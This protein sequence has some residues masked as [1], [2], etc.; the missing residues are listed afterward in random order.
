MTKSLNLIVITD[1]V[2]TSQIDLSV[3]CPHL[4]LELNPGITVSNTIAGA[5]NW[6]VGDN[7]L[8]E[9]EGAGATIDFISGPT[10]SQI[11]LQNNQS[12]RRGANAEANQI[13]FTGSGENQMVDGASTFQDCCFDSA[14][15]FNFE[16]YVNLLTITGCL[17]TAPSKLDSNIGLLKSAIIIGNLFEN[18][19]DVVVEGTSEFVFTNNILGKVLATNLL[20]SGATCSNMEISDNVFLSGELDISSTS[21]TTSSISSN[22]W[23]EIATGGITITSSTNQSLNISNNITNFLHINNAGPLNDTS[24]LSNTLI[25][26]LFISGAVDDCSISN[27]T[28]ITNLGFG[29]TINEITLSA[30]TCDTMTCTSVASNMSCVGNTFEGNITFASLINEST[31]AGNKLFNGLPLREGPVNYE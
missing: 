13:Q 19:G 23:K 16:Y 2:E 7:T 15:A 30:N 8:L 4:W 11:I 3:H 24:I 28:I 17:F 21:L 18:G 20:I 29:S 27:N 22:S 12:F 10:S 14:V 5:G 1:V 25:Q 9:L 26:D 6:F 31:F